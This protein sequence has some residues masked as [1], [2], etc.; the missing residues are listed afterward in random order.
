MTERQA[1]EAIAEAFVTGWKA[2]Y[3]DP[4]SVPYVLENN[5]MPSATTFVMLTVIPLPG[6]WLTMGVKDTRRVERRGTI[7]VKCWTPANGG[8]GAAVDLCDSAR[9][10]LEGATLTAGGD[11]LVILQG[12]SQRVGTDGTWYMRVASFPFRYYAAA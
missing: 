8:A 2:A 3:G 10:I 5:A 4:P 12:D 6:Q 11:D 1:L 9:S 7:M